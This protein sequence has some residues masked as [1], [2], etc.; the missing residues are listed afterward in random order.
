MNLKFLKNLQSTILLSLLSLFSNICWAKE[1]PEIK[2]I[3]ETDSS[4]QYLIQI[5]KDIKTIHPLL[6]LFHPIAI[7]ENNH[8]YIFDFDSSTRKYNYI[9]KE[10]V[11]FPMPEGVRA[12]FPLSCYNSKP[13]CIITKDIFNNKDGYVTIFHEFI[14]C[15]QFTTCELQ[16]KKKLQIAREASERSDYSWELNHSFPYQDSLFINHYTLFLSALT[17]G[18]DEAVIEYRKKLKK[19]LTQSDFEYMIWTEW[20]EG[21]ARL[22][23]NRIKSC[24][25]LAE[26]LYGAEIP[27]NRVTFYYGGSEFID[28]L[29]Q[30]DPDLYTNIESLFNRMLNY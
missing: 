19:D 9:K 22:I 27:Y 14:H 18:H 16:L 30:K 12:S 17:T 1:N 2:F 13:A 28:Y 23:E 11:S 21:F 10:P 7:V 29:I 15:S 8:F 24:F 3:I 26:N 5:Q 6:N 25:K 20:K 4:L